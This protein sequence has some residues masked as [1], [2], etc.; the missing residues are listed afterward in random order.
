MHE[1]SHV[2]IENSLTGDFINFVNLTSHCV[3]GDSNFSN[4]CI[5]YVSQSNIPQVTVLKMMITNHHIT[6]LDHDKHIFVKASNIKVMPFMTQTKE[7][8][9]MALYIVY[10]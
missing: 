4:N 2:A 9:T 10:T 6:L 1:I 7:G 5:N 3:I 8:S